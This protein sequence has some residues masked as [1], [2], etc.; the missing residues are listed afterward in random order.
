LNEKLSFV[1]QVVEQW[2]GNSGLGRLDEDERG[3]S[4]KLFWDGLVVNNGQKK[5]DMVT[6][7]RY[8]GDDA[9]RSR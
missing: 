7:G 8:G 3:V 2:V 4:E 9:A 6:V 1:L 5:T